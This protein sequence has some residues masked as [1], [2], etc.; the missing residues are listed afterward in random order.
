MA[1][2]SSSSWTILY[3][4]ILNSN[5]SDVADAFLFCILTFSMLDSHSSSLYLFLSGIYSGS[6]CA[7]AY[8]ESQFYT[9]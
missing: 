6:I 5:L 9:R 1:R 4:S 3:M 7:C 2:G 8:A